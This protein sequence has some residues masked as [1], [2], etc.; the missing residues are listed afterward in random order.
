MGEFAH[1]FSRPGARLAAV[2]D[3]A[4]E[5]SKQVFGPCAFSDY[6]SAFLLS[7]QRIWILVRCDH[8]ADLSFQRDERLA[9][10]GHQLERY[11]LAHV[12]EQPGRSA[13]DEYWRYD[14]LL[15]QCDQTACA[16]Q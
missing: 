16:H 1:W 12:A 13:A 3:S 14:S 9:E 8:A 6:L 5:L 7:V 10:R 4:V 2:L 11:Q 15:D